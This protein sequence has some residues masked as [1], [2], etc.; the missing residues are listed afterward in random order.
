MRAARPDQL[1][2]IVDVVDNT[3]TLSMVRTGAIL[4]FR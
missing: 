4:D 3:A 2:F 1:A